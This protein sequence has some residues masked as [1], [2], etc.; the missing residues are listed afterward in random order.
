MTIG[1]KDYRRKRDMLLNYILT[2]IGRI[3]SLD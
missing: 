2:I 3:D 1:G